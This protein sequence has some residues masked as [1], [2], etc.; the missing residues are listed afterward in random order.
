M[1]KCSLLLSPSHSWVDWKFLC[2]CKI[3]PK[4]W[5]KGLSFKGYFGPTML[6]FDGRICNEGF[7]AN[8]E[9]KLS[10]KSNDLFLCRGKGEFEQELFY[11]MICLRIFYLSGR[12]SKSI[13]FFAFSLFWL[14]PSLSFNLKNKGFY[15]LHCVLEFKIFL[16]EWIWDSHTFVFSY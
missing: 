2:I 8:P 14:A 11:D 12:D 13:V 7:L 4:F 6:F 9:S 5:G 1:N 16:Y 10:F 3:L 15:L